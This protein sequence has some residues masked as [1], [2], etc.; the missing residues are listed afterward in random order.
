M[1]ITAIKVVCT[2]G[3]NI[4]LYEDVKNIISELR[5]RHTGYTDF[6]MELKRQVYSIIYKQLKSKDNTY[7]QTQLLEYL[8]LPKDVFKEQYWNMY[9]PDMKLRQQVYHN[10][11]I[12]LNY[13]EVECNEIYRGILHYIISQADQ[14]T[15]TF[16]DMFGKMGLVP[17]FCANGYS[18]RI[19]LLARRNYHQLVQFQNALKK[20]VKVYKHIRAFTKTIEV[21]GI[22]K[23]KEVLISKINQWLALFSVYQDWSAT[24]Y[25]EYTLAARYFMCNCLRTEYWLDSKLEKTYSYKDGKLVVDDISSYLDG[26][27]MSRS[28]IKQ[29]CGLSKEDF[30]KFADMYVKKI[31]LHLI[32]TDYLN[33]ES[34]STS[35]V[36]QGLNF[37]FDRQFLYIDMPKYI[38]E[39][40]RFEFN[41]AHMMDILKVLKTYRGN[42]IM[43]WKTYVE[44]QN[45]NSPYYRLSS[46]EA[47]YD[48]D[49]TLEVIYK[50]MLNMHNVKP[51]YVYVYRDKDRNRP[52]SIAFITDIDCSETDDRAFMDK[53][54]VGFRDGGH[55][56]KMT[57]PEF[58]DKFIRNSHWKMF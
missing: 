38:R 6:P 31:H 7:T 24:G 13:A 11:H 8:G 52:Q 26:T 4:H 14:R 9:S 16:F 45:E 22:E 30:C 43:T 10:L 3:V 54:D 44:N 27:K 33:I 58:I 51:L 36:K 5:S 46:K 12:P 21:M 34:I 55:I 50:E 57:M 42:W 56:R 47:D 17:L 25:D 41:G 53:Y 35:I 20:P 37:Q 23:Q 49:I 32:E 2:Q 1:R 15:D 29:L 19:V 48:N 40:K 18:N 28:R 39:Y